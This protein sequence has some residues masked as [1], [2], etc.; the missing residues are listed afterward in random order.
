VQ[1]PAALL[2]ALIVLSTLTTGWHYLIDIVAGV[3]V[4]VS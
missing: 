2:A 1:E 3:L 4:A